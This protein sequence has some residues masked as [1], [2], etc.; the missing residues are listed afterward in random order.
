MNPGWWFD[1]DFIK[2]SSSICIGCSAALAVAETMRHVFPSTSGFFVFAVNKNGERHMS[3]RIVIAQLQI[4]PP[5]F[6]AYLKLAKAHAARSLQLDPGCRQFDV[7]AA[8]EPKHTIMLYEV[9]DDEASFQ[10][11]ANAPRMADYRAATKGMVLDR[12]LFKCSML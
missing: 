3:K 5:Q 2:A 11:H 6:D 9:Y 8:E 7:M 10:G 12:K 4:D 1:Y